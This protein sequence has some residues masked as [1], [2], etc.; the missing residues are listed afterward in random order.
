VGQRIASGFF[1]YA[2][3]EL[4]KAAQIQH[5]KS[6]MEGQ[7]AAQQ[8]QTF[9]QVEM[10]GDKWA[11][12]GY[13]L[14]EAQQLS[15]GLLTAQRAEIANGLYE[16]D[17]EQYRA[18]FMERVD[19]MLSGTG[20]QRT[21]ELARD[22]V[23]KQMPVL[24]EDHMTQHL[25]WKEQKNF[26]ALTNS[27]DVISMD[28]TSHDALI[29]FATGGE[30][31]PTAGLSEDRRRE[32]VV[33]GI[34]R[35]F[36]ND[37][38]QAYAVLAASGVL[39]DMPVAQQQ[40]IKAARNAFETRA[41][42]E[43]NAEFIAAERDL[44]SQIERGALEPQQAMELYGDLMAQHNM[45]M[46]MQE[47]GAIYD[48]AGSGV[49]TR[50]INTATAAH[51]AMMRGDREVAVR[52]IRKS[53]AG[54]ESG[55]NTAAFRT[56]RDN[57]S[58]GGRLQFGAARLADYAAATG[59]T[60]I[61]PDEFKNMSDAEQAAVEDWHVNNVL[62]HIEAKGYDQLIGQSIN[63]VTL[64]YSGMVA[65]A[66][67]GGTGGLD[68]MI[69][70]GGQYNPAD[71]LGTSLTDYLSKHGNGVDLTPE[72]MQKA[73]QHRISVLRE[74]AA[75]ETYEQ[76][77]PQLDAIDEAF[78]DPNTTM[79]EEQWRAARADVRGQY[80]V[81]KTM[82]DAKFE[83]DVALEV[84]AAAQATLDE[85]TGLAAAA[86]IEQSV[87]KFDEVVSAYTTGQASAE[88]VLTAQQSLQ[89]EQAAVRE[90]FGIPLDADEE[91]KQYRKQKTAIQNAVIARQKFD[92]EQAEIN[93][94]E[95]SGTLNELPASLQK[96]AI[97]SQRAGVQ[98]EVEEAMQSGQV[99]QEQAMQMYDARMADYYS[100][101]GVV[102]PVLERTMNGF[103]S[104]GLVDKHGEPNAQYIEAAEQYRMLMQRNPTVADKY[105]RAENQPMLDAVLE[106][107]GSGDLA[108]AV[109]T[110]G[111]RQ[112][113]PRARTT[114]ELMGDPMVQ[115]GIEVEVQKFLD[116]EDI[117]GVQQLF[118][119]AAPGA[120]WNRPAYDVFAEENRTLIQ[121]RVETA[122][123]QAHAREPLARSSE[124]VA[125]AA[126]R[127]KERT[128]I[129][130]GIAVPLPMNGPSMN[131]RLF[132]AR[133]ADF[134]GVEGVANAALMD[135]FRSQ[136][137][138][139][140]YGFVNEQTTGEALL[141]MLPLTA[142]STGVRPFQVYQDRL[143]GQLVV[144][145]ELASG[146]GSAPIALD[147]RSIGQ[148]Y[149]NKQTAAAAD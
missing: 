35:A 146:G 126:R 109:R 27:V 141:S 133:A 22:Q 120:V 115:Q 68:K 33:A 15:S 140:Q 28:P 114:D 89:Q 37:N 86:R 131:E 59:T 49:R 71:Q 34:A 142:P 30:G 136:A 44:M 75:V 78:R 16:S 101:T 72:Q 36:E 125:S 111:V 127:V 66:H 137:F 70:T 45:T 121:G 99:D 132:G 80:G 20:D 76:M 24:V 128:P 41:R 116:S 138:R 90:E 148:A 14:V 87:N 10:G 12:E 93:L 129:L 6:M 69:A 64:T 53:L 50:K 130:G 26:E 5:E 67:L 55:G 94:A 43:F 149:I 119:N 60:P 135:H 84:Q 73:A 52:L 112:A 81:G 113:P 108:G 62:D 102:D 61:L 118:G 25:Q 88:D 19:G 106:L 145:F 103:L 56:N 144:Q 77:Q 31:S 17:P 23:L 143:S 95:V 47:A 29:A 7:M 48:T 1:D 2:Q 18:R 51:E 83:R 97:E 54:T 63:G 82:A 79:T 32:A 21:R 124:L 8:G 74:A 9:E 98:K 11:L 123:A 92:D 42:K 38:P 134:A 85:A 4:G 139:E 110:L 91:I 57:R 65:V 122:V 105:I 3:A 40:K 58:Y 107:A 39:K 13:R 100:Q 147:L 117:T 104:A 46:T 96:R